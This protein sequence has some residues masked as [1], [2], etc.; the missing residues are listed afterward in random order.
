MSFDCS[1][2][3]AMNCYGNDFIQLYCCLE[4]LIG[5]VFTVRVCH[6]EDIYNLALASCVCSVVCCE[7]VM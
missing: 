6:S 4:V 2:K 3:I 5:D 1:L 7:I